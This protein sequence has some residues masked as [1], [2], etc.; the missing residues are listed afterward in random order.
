MIAYFDCFSGISGDMTLGAFIDL[1]VSVKFLKDSLAEI[2]LT[3]FDL[4]VSSIS[5]N[6]IMAKSVEVDKEDDKSSRHYAE[7]K[8]LLSRC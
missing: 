3:G 6:G 1:G 7:I 2:P 5:R 8:S 4:S